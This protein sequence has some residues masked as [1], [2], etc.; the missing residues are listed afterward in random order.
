MASDGQKTCLLPSTFVLVNT[1]QLELSVTCH[2]SVTSHFVTVFPSYFDFKLKY[3][4]CK[5]QNFQQLSVLAYQTILCVR[6]VCP[7]GFA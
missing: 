3:M 5:V 7:M 6:F 4:C 1:N 2:S